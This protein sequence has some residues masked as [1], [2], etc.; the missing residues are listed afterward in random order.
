MPY[1]VFAM[2]FPLQ[3]HL[4]LALFTAVQL[5]TIS[6]HG[7][8]ERLCLYRPVVL[9]SH[10]AVDQVYLTNGTI[11]EPIINGADHHSEHHLKFTV[12]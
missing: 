1:H 7:E 2:L 3:R 11:L 6:I 10:A 12:S 5:W 9:R 4:F 8:T